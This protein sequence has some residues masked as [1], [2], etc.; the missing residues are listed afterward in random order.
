MS[1]TKKITP[2]FIKK[3]ENVW[4]SN[5]LDAYLKLINDLESR[6]FLTVINSK[7]MYCLCFYTDVCDSIRIKLSLSAGGGVGYFNP[8]LTIYSKLAFSNTLDTDFWSPS[9]HCECP[10][11]LKGY[12]CVYINRLGDYLQETII[13]SPI[14]PTFKIIE[15][16]EPS[17]RHPSFLPVFDRLFMPIIRRIDC[18]E[19][20]I[21]LVKETLL[22]E[23]SSW[24]ISDGPY[25]RVRVTKSY[26]E[27]LMRK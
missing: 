13:N 6:G 15:D 4:G 25:Q 16:V 17:L 27:C 18:D 20:L 22:Y 21:E 5:S 12:L 7:D 23:K 19:K 9:L 14:R 10:N 11:Y 24:M 2:G 8:I 1:T 3:F 26:L